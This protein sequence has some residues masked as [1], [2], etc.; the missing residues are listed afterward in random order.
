MSDRLSYLQRQ[1]ALLREHLAWIDSE[2]S[3]EAPTAAPAAPTADS[4]PTKASMLSTSN[5]VVPEPLGEA[6]ALIEKYASEERQSPDAIRRGCLY[7]FISAVSLLT[8][9]V[10]AVWLLFY[11]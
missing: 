11:R 5:A 6:D 2:I 1:R 10:I 3:R 4:T 8:A 7:V 9:C